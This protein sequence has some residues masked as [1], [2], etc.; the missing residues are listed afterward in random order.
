MARDGSV[1][2][3]DLPT[4]SGDGFEHNVGYAPQKIEALSDVRHVALGGSLGCALHTG[5]TVSCWGLGVAAWVDGYAGLPP[6]LKEP[7]KIDVLAGTKKLGFGH[8]FT[9]RLDGEGRVSCWG[10]NFWGQLGRG[11]KETRHD[12]QIIESLTDVVDLAVGHSHAC[13]LTRT[14][15]GSCW[16]KNTSGQL[17]TGKRGIKANERTPVAIAFPDDD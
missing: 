14:G 7:K 15:T 5:D 11:G 4:V 9:C 10:K 17:G 8:G 3:W 6:P 12:P 2:W 1:W 13:A 16:G